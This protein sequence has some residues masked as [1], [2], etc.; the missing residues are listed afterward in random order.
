MVV[1]E[2]DG[3]GLNPHHFGQH[4]LQAEQRAVGR[5]LLQQHARLQAPAGVQTE[6]IEALSPPDLSLIHI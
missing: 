2:N 5:A 4:G 6:H 3:V 1:A